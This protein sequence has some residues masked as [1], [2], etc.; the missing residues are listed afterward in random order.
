MSTAPAD[1]VTQAGH[2]ADLQA[3][4][5]VSDTLCA[6]VESHQVKDEPT[7]RALL[8]E[9]VRSAPKVDTVAR[10]KA[11]IEQHPELVTD[12]RLTA[13]G[14]LARAGELKKLGIL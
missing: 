11:F 13:A 5:A 10:A 2:L 14:K 12:H 1:L 9:Q 7:V 8:A 3:R 6:I 4:V